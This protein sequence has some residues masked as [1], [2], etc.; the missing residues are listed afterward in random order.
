MHAFIDLIRKSYSG[1]SR[2]VWLL[3][4]ITLIN[5]TG[6]MVILFMTLYLTTE[7]QFTYTQAGIAMSCFGAGS[8]VGG[9]TGGWL[10]D[11]VGYY[12]TMFWSLLLAGVAFLGLMYMTTFLSFCISVFFVSSIA[13]AFRPACMASI[14]AYAKPENHNRSLSLIRLA[15]NLGFACGAAATGILSARYGYHWLFIID[16]ITC[17][18]AAGFLLLVLKEKKERMVDESGNVLLDN[19]GLAIE[20]GASA[21]KDQLYLRFI[22][23]KM[24]A[25]V[26]FMQL[27]STFPVYMKED[28]L[29]SE[30]QYGLIMMGNGLLIFLLEM[31]LVYILEKRYQRMTLV[32][33]G[34][35]L[36]ASGYMLL[37][38]A[39]LSVALVVLYFMLAITVGEVIGFPFSNAFALS[40]STVGRRGEFMGLYSMS[41]SVAFI[42]A[43]LLG[44]RLAEEYGFPVLWGVIAFLNTIAVL[45][46]MYV[47]SQLKKESARM[48]RRAVLGEV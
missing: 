43:P 26:A 37:G 15:I 1:L 44:M 12:R 14:S 10:T 6:S 34:Y 16:G 4:L 41:F 19:G 32:V 8:V 40:R 38:F 11:R 48:E 46:F 9:W 3:A 29:F 20:K 25:A 28:L 21:Y 22:F 17:M 24:V 31:P 5:R 39:H 13:D 36:I 2:D 30:D 47:K 45:G 33:I 23:F 42:I 18:L 27:F 35:A 7:L